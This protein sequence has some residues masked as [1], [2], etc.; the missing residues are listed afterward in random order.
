VSVLLGVGAWLVVD[1]VNPTGRI[2]TLA[3]LALIAVVGTGLY[4]LAMQLLR[5]PVQLP[6]EAGEMAE[7]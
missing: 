5:D 6:H 4:V 7:T 1:A 2:T 3:L